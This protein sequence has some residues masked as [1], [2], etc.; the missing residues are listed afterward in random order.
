MS[1]A[2]RV[3]SL[4]GGA[5]PGGVGPRPAAGGG[6]GGQGRLGGFRRGPALKGW[7]SKHQVGLVHGVFTFAFN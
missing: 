5:E 3:G 6:P 4:V 2:L 1:R 7:E